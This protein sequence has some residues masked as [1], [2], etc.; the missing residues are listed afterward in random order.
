M[1]DGLLKLKDDQHLS[2]EIPSDCIE[3]EPSFGRPGWS[4]AN[5]RDLS[6]RRRRYLRDSL[7]DTL[8]EIERLGVD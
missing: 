2:I 8:A 7:R 6:P 4:T 5:V 1:L 3:I